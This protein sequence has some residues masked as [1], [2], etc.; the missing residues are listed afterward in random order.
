MMQTT[1]RTCLVLQKLGQSL[2]SHV[3]GEFMNV[4]ESTEEVGIVGVGVSSVRDNRLSEIRH[5][6]E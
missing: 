2:R 1:S 3:I 4:F 6:G 5:Y